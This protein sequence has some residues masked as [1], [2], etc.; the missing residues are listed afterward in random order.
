M[1]RTNKCSLN[2]QWYGTD[3]R[4]ARHVCVY[5]AFTLERLQDVGGGGSRLFDGALNIG[6]LFIMNQKDRF[7]WLGWHACE[8]GTQQYVYMMIKAAPRFLG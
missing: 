5:V 6:G 7:P 4:M 3:A 8:L 1:D 2:K